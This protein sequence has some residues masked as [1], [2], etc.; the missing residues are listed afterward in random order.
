MIVRPL[1]E[2]ALDQLFQLS[3]VLFIDINAEAFLEINDVDTARHTQTEERCLGNQIDP[4]AKILCRTKSLQPL[5]ILSRIA[6]IRISLM[7]IE[8]MRRYAESKHG[9]EAPVLRVMS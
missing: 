9:V 1:D 8:R 5:D 2:T 3:G 4:F 7:T 6:L